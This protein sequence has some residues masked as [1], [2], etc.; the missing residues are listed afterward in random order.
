MPS[1]NFFL[2]VE[3]SETANLGVCVMEQQNSIHCLY[4]SYSNCFL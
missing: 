4:K 3:H 1:S 2:T